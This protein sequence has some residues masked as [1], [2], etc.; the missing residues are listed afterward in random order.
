MSDD[1]R[2]DRGWLTRRPVLMTIMALGMV[3]TLAGAN[4][5]FAVFTDRATTGTNSAT[6]RAEARSADLQIATGTLVPED[7]SITCG[8][9]VENLAS[10]II[11]ATDM[12]PLGDDVHAFVCLKNVGSRSLDVTTSV[13]D[14]FDTDPQCTGDE[15]EVDSCGT[16]EF[17]E[18]SGVLHVFLSTSDCVTPGSSL[19]NTTLDTMVSTPF[20][21]GSVASGALLCVH[22][23][24]QDQAQGDDVAITQSDTAT[25]KFAYDGTAT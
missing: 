1:V 21:L 2:R 4:G 12:V 5:V 9:F 14:L 19:G 11:T 7:G 18:L 3:V 24:I 23:D 13:I 20:S 10:G 6:S 8:T 22:V 17:G 15:S 25:W 16:G